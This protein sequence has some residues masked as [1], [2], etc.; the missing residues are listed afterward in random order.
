MYVT[1]REACKQLGLHPN[2]L[3]KLADNEKIKY[4]R[5]ESGQRRYDV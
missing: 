5:T 4:Y 3:R 1:S 2:T